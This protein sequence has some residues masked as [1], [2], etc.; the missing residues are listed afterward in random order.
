M[1]LGDTERAVAFIDAVRTKT[2]DEDPFGVGAGL[3]DYD[4]DTDAESL[5]AE[6]FY[7]RGA[8]LYL[9]GLRLIDS[10]R[11]G[12]PGPGNGPFERNR[13]FYP[14]PFQERNANP[15]TPTDPSI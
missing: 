10:R 8:E 15:N 7:Q 2:A 14:Y 1:N 11:L 9:Q 13:N 6:I 3:N 12:G 4:G 5:R